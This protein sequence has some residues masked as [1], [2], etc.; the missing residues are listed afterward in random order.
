MTDNFMPDQYSSGL[1]VYLDFAAMG[2]TQTVF[3]VKS[4]DGNYVTLTN[5][6]NDLTFKAKPERVRPLER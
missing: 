5:L 1:R 2:Q 4:F 3:I 6:E